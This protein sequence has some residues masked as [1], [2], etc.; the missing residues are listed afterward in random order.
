AYVIGA[1]R[2]CLAYRPAVSP[3]HTICDEEAGAGCRCYWTARSQRIGILRSIRFAVGV[4]SPS[5]R[6]CIDGEAPAHVGDTVVGEHAGWSE[7]GGDVVWAAQHRYA[8][9]T[10]VRGGH[11]ISCDE[12]RTTAGR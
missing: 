3:R 8:C 5:R 2:H 6:T 9:S 11:V 4:S 1:A 7:S 10:A 12:I